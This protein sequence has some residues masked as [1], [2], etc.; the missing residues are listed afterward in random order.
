VP[1]N[2]ASP[3]TDHGPVALRRVRFVVAYDGSGFRGFAANHSLP[4]V[5]KALTEALS[6]VTRHS[7]SLVGAGRTDAGVHA[8]G[9]VVSCDLPATVRL[10]NVVRRVNSMCGPEVVIREADWVSDDF[11]ARFS[12]VWRQYRYTVV[13]SPE[14]N[15]F[16]RDLAWYIHRPLSLPAMQLACDPLIGE[17]DFTSFCRKPKQS[18]G[19]EPSMHRRVM[20]ARWTDVSEE[21]GGFTADQRV[22]RFEIRANAFCHQMV[23]SIVGTMVEVGHGKCHAGDIR[24]IMRARDRKAA[25]T[26]LAPPH[27]LILWEVGYGDGEAEQG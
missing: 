8:W 19:E 11:S 14:P 13:N 10:K 9:Q 2:G 4:T 3:E 17:N 5:V 20:L 21:M 26:T 6:L 12:A 23:R 27:G 18:N 22:L 16:L 24:A 7:V 25:A 1:E 15:P